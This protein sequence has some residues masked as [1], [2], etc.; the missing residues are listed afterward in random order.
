MMG[1]RVIIADTTGK[2]VSDSSGETN[3]AV[4]SS[5]QL[6]GGLPI[7]VGGQSA[8]IVLIGAGET[9]PGTPQ[10]SFFAQ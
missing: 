9:Q 4:L 10:A 2:F 6:A 1:H 8:G 3:G 5:E 7:Q